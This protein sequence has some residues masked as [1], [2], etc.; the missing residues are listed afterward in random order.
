MQ[1]T[2]VVSTCTAYINAPLDVLGDKVFNQNVVILETICYMATCT[3]FIPLLV[4][5][6]TPLHVSNLS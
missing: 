2:I 1:Y 3:H 5:K 4:T 6:A